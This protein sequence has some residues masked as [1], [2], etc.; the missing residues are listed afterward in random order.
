MI[1]R[2]WRS[3]WSFPRWRGAP[4]R[5][6]TA[7]PEPPP[8]FPAGVEQVT[9]D[10]VVVDR[11]RQPVTDLTQ[12]ELEVYEDGVQ[13]AIVSF[14]AFQ[15]SPAAGMELAAPAPRIS[16]NAAAKDEGRGRTFVIVF[17]DVHLT[18]Y[19]ARR[20][21]QAVVEFLTKETRE[22][23]RVTLVGAGSGNFWS[24]AHA[25]GPGRAHRPGE[26]PGGPS[27]PGDDRATACPITRPCGSTCTATAPS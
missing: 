9:V 22:G 13:Q 2:P 17:D 8:T 20:A 27:R 21:R 16:T 7:Q 18:A 24:D 4:G 25:R 15:V 19:T 3:V 11:K 10:V 5:S 23:D 1:R 12:E 26:A 6:R 14:D